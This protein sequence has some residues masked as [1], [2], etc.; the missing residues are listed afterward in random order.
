MASR[1]RT[2]ED[3]VQVWF[4]NKRARYRKRMSK[5]NS[6]KCAVKPQVNLKK[7]TPVKEPNS[8]VAEPITPVSASDYKFNARTSISNQDTGYLSFN[9]TSN[10]NSTYLTS[11]VTSFSSMYL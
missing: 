1:L 2:T 7:V 4:Q 6:A 5:E 11:P 3:R 8:L 9:T 10:S